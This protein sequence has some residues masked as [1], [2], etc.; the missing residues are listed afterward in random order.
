MK[1]N[2]FLMMILFLQIVMFSCA[3]KPNADTEPKESEILDMKNVELNGTNWVKTRFVDNA[4]KKPLANR[5]FVIYVIFDDDRECGEI[6][7]RSDENGW[8]YVR[9]IPEGECYADILPEE[10]ES[11]SA[12][13][14]DSDEEN[15][16][17]FSTEPYVISRNGDSVTAFCGEIL[18]SDFSKINQKDPAQVLAAFFESYLSGGNEWQK[19]VSP[20]VRISSIQGDYKEFYGVPE[21]ISITIDRKKF[22]PRRGYFKI[23]IAFAYQGETGEGEDDATMVQDK[24]SGNWFVTE[25]PR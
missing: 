14:F 22:D 20:D 15:D 5:R 12:R 9:N 17:D 21:S 2:I 13:D 10:T 18:V 25:L 3:T 11:D 1:K 6:I 16:G 23:K 4:S 7:V 24:T 8:I 19:F